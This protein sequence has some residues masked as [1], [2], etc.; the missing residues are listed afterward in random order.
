MKETCLFVTAVICLIMA[1]SCEDNFDELNDTKQRHVTFSFITDS[2][3]SNVLCYNGSYSLGDKEGLDSD[4]RLRI[5]TYCYDSKDSLIY[6][7]KQITEKLDGQKVKVR[8][9]NEDR[10]YRFV[11]VADVVKYDS[12]VDYYETWFQ[13]GTMS[14][15]SFYFYADNRNEE[16]KYNVIGTQMLELQPQNQNIDIK[17]TPITYNG[18]CI[19]NHLN[20]TDHLSGYVVYC[21]VFNLKTMQW[22]RRHSMA[23]NF[24][25]RNPQK[26]VVSIPVSLS[27]PDSV[28]TV[29]LRR[30][31]LAGIDSVLIDIP[32]KGCRPFVAVFDCNKLEL[33]KCNFY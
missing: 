30:N 26:S 23:Y 1:T 27:Y 14:W 4:Y 13:L 21:S 33:E 9:L 12:K 18:Y 28:I 8:H 6:S 29:K 15:T 5:S 2:L 7:D 19:L 25:F 17:F 32:N 16:A 11:F 22:R 24:D 20:T 31:I 10:T 3:F